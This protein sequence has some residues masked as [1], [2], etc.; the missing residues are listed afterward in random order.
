LRSLRGHL[1]ANLSQITVRAAARALGTSPRTLQRGLSE[2]GTSFRAEVERARVRAAEAL[3]AETNAKL[4]VIA[5]QVGCS[6]PSSFSRLFR[7]LTGE[8]PSDFRARRP[9]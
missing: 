5:L 7:R 8:S 6:S 1:A 9:A 3:L 4:E 2:L